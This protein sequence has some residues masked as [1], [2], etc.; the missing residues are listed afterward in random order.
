MWEDEGAR[1]RNNI[2]ITTENVGALEQTIGAN[3]LTCR[4]ERSRPIPSL[5]VTSGGAPAPLSSLFIPNQK[6]ASS[7]P[8]PQNNAMWWLI[9]A[10][11]DHTAVRNAVARTGRVP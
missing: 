8:S 5:L 2:Y 10:T 4:S 3:Q 7:G 9:L 1:P 11:T 6:E